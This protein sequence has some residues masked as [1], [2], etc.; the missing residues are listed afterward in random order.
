MKN[1]EGLVEGVLVKL[2]EWKWLLPQL[3][4]RGRVLIANNLKAS[5][6]WHKLMFFLDPPRS[7]I[8]EIHKTL[9]KFFWTGKYWLK[10]AV[11]YLPVHE[12]GQGLIDIVNRV[13]VF[14]LLAAQRLLYQ[15]WMDAACALLRKY[16]RMGLDKQLSVMSLGGENLDGL[17]VF[18]QSILQSWQTLSCSIVWDGSYQ[19]VYDE[20]LFF[21]SLIC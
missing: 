12:E 3:S 14:H 15:Q 18:Y 20:S 7:I 17:T 6:L 11:L 5:T 8:D 19:W 13:A 16:R 2:S 1:W 10:A 9:V 21:N 4:Y